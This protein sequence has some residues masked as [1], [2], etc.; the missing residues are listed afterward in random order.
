MWAAVVLLGCSV[1]P[2]TL[3]FVPLLQHAVSPSASWRSKSVC[4]LVALR[5]AAQLPERN[6]LA[7]KVK[8]AGEQDS[9]RDVYLVG[10][11][12]YNPVSLKRVGDTVDFLAEDN[13]LSAGVCA[14]L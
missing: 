2:P 5:C 1:L 12:H 6:V 4:P 8:V 14:Y 3:S 13:S 9:M 7:M 10:T 11:M